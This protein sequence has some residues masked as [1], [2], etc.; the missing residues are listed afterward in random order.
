VAEL[1]ALLPE[2]LDRVL[3]RAFLRYLLPTTT[4]R[5]LDASAVRS[6]VEAMV[7]RKKVA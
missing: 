4:G 6:I 5:H 7:K 2:P 1:A 3:R